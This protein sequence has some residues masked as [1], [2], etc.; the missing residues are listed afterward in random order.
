[1]EEHEVIPVNPLDEADAITL[2]EKKLGDLADRRDLAALAQELEFMPLAIVQ[3]AAYI[4]ER[5]PRCSIR[6]YIHKFRR[7][8]RGGTTLLNHEAGHLRRDREAKNSIIITWQI[9]F[10]HIRDARPSAADLLSLMSFFDRQGIPEALLR[11]RGVTDDV[12]QRVQEAHKNSEE[13]REDDG[14]G[15]DSATES[16]TSEGFEED[17]LILKSYSFISINADTTT[18]EMHRLVQLAMRIWLDTHGQLERWRQQ[19]V[20]N[21]NAEFPVGEHENWTKCQALFP[22]VKAAIRHQP[23]GEDSILEWASLLYGAAWYS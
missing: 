7:S 4:S 15:D 17:V 14:G 5:A 3:A 1:V 23:K 8:D 11:N 6:Q 20:R 16:S 12:G 13:E 19:F 18:F 21:L 2:L 9:S 22:H 10:D